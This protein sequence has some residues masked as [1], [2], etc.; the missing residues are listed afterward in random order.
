MRKGW[1]SHAG[2]FRVEHYPCPNPGEPVDFG[3]PAKG[4]LHTTEG[5]LPS[6][7]AVFRRHFAPTFTVAPGRIL[8]H[9]PLGTM[10]AALENHSGGVQTNRDC[11]VQIEVVGF[12]QKTLWLPH[13]ST[14]AP[15]ASLMRV[16]VQAA[17]IPLRHV[18][19][20]RNPRMWERTSGWLGHIDVPENSHWD[21]GHV[22]YHR[23]LRVAQLSQ[24]P[25]HRAPPGWIEVKP[26]PRKTDRVRTLALRA[27][28]RRAKPV[29]C[30]THAKESA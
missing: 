15:L 17:G 22:D 28:A 20:G 8:Q 6:A 24:H 16:L 29:S 4:I 27:R 7:L 19:V 13:S 14:L 5:S 18:P 10:A 23:L 26:K 9:V 11:R 21:P 3:A 1:L 30:H 12:S 2:K 25:V